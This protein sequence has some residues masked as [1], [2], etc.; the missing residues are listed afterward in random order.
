[1]SSEQREHAAS[2]RFEG[3]A[4]ASFQGPNRIVVAPVLEE[5]EL[6]R[7]VNVDRPLHP[8]LVL[9]LVSNYERQARPRRI[10]RYYAIVHMAISTFTSFEAARALA[11]RFPGI[12]THVARLRLPG[13]VGFCIDVPARGAHRSLWGAPVQIAACVVEVSRA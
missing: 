7:V 5:V 11:R 6:F 2:K 13:G 1:M 12:G 4:V 9:D 8:G 10:E 3:A